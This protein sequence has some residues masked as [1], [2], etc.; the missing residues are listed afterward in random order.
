ML[1]NLFFRKLHCTGNVA[2]IAN[3][4]DCLVA[5]TWL[6]FKY[7]CVFTPIRLLG[8]VALDVAFRK[9][10]SHKSFVWWFAVAKKL[11]GVIK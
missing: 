8:N 6:W 7:N 2:I 4:I 10:A 9:G 1:F 3:K 11:W 5:K